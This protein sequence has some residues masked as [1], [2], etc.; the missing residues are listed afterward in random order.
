MRDVLDAVRQDDAEAAVRR[1]RNRAAFP[2]FARIVDEVRAAGGT[3]R[4]VWAA[5]VDGYRVGDVPDN[6]ADIFR[7]IPVPEA[8]PAL[9]CR[10]TRGRP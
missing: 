7:D 5:N 9:G 1:E 2:E 4:L 3:A 8:A 6:W 10:G